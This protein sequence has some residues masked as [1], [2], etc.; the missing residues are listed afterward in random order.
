M[1]VKTYNKFKT[2][3]TKACDKHVKA[4]KK[5]ITGGFQSEEGCCPIACVLGKPKNDEYFKALDKKLGVIIDEEEYWNFIEGF[6]ANEDF[7]P[8]RAKTQLF[9]LGRALRKKYIKE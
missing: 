5:I 1:N 7:D 6:D 4:G 8:E 9:K 2:L 3:L